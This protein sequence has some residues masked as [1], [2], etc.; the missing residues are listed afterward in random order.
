MAGPVGELMA[1]DPVTLPVD[2]T[3]Q[4]AARWMRDRDIGAVLVVD[5]ERLHG[6]VTDRDLVVRALAD[7]GDLSDC[8][9]RDVCSQE[10]VTATPEE[11]VD[12][13]VARMR[14]HAVRRVAVVEGK[15]PLGV[16]SLGDAAIEKSPN[17]ALGAISGAEGNI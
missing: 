1:R 13:V 15:R 17:S 11:D 6:I 9:L 5:G 10:L 7:R 16:F 14:D 12:T 3:A 2:A 8:H 4:D